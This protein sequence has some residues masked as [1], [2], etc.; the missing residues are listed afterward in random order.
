MCLGGVNTAIEEGQRLMNGSTQ[1]YASQPEEMN[2][3]QKQL[4]FFV[5]Y[6]SVLQQ[7][8]FQVKCYQSCQG[9]TEI[10]LISS[11]YF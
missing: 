2:I 8:N 4:H 9:V 6:V 10:Y 11:S 5:T 1:E 3:E 7:N